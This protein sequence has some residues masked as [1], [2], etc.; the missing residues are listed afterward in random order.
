M[1]LEIKFNVKKLNSKED[2]KIHFHISFQN[3]GG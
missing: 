2:K 1:G 3:N